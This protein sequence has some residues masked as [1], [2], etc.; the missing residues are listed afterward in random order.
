MKDLA[1]KRNQRAKRIRKGL[2]RVGSRPRLSI[3]RSN[4]Y[5][6]AQ[7]ID[8]SKAETIASITDKSLKDAKGTKTEKA[9]Q[10]GE[11][12]AELALKKKIKQ[13]YFDRGK[14]RYHGRVKALAEA[15]RKKGLEF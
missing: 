7:V 5:I 12:I 2:K 10:V 14:Y 8:D 4:K 1:I 9:A 13:V 6:W 15:A 3:F 11:K